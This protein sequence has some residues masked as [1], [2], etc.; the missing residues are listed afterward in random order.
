MTKLICPECH[1]ENEA[2]RIYCHECG[3]KLD[4]SKVIASK[5][6]DTRLKERNRVRQMFDTRRAKMRLLFFKIAKL[7][8]GA[9]LT[10]AV[11]LMILPPLDAPP[12]P[13]DALVLSQIGLE[14]ENAVNERRATPLQYSEQQINE[15]L[16]NV[17]KGKKA[18]NKPFLPFK[19][20]VAAFSE[21]KCTITAERSFFGYSLFTSTSHAVQLTEGKISSS[22]KGGAIGR[23]PIYPQLMQYLDIVFADVWKALE[24]ERKLVSKA[25]GIEFHDK[26]VVL[27]TASPTAP[28]PPAPPQ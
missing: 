28:A 11:I 15:Y 10:A 8:L 18:L 2:E 13:K 14:V 4:R 9:L 16:I 12:L 6:T 17:L 20:A 27:I 1:R 5:P 24:R 26:S 19:R 25:S 22:N 21:G 23:L 7:I 3:A